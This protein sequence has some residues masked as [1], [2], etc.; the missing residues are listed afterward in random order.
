MTVNKTVGTQWL[1]WPISRQDFS[2]HLEI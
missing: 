2:T 1:M